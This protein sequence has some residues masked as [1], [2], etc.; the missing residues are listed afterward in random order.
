MIL[1]QQ[2]DLALAYKKQRTVADAHPLG[3]GG[4][5]GD[6]DQR[7]AHAVQRRIFRDAFADR[8]IGEL[9]C[10]VKPRRHVS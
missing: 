3:A 6:A 9:E 10:L 8:G 7:A 1:I 2:R 5:E 4:P